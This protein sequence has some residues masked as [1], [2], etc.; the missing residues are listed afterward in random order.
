MNAAG[1]I[2]DVKILVSQLAT[3]HNTVWQL[4]EDAIELAKYN[5]NHEMLDILLKI[6]CEMGRSA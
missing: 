3:R 2:R 1:D 4:V 5:S 6:E